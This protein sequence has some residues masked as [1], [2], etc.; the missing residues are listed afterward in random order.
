MKW[1]DTA[2]SLIEEKAKA[3]RKSANGYKGT[4]AYWEKIK[5]QWASGELPQERHPCEE[6]LRSFDPTRIPALI[7]K[8]TLE[9]RDAEQEADYWEAELLRIVPRVASGESPLENYA[10]WRLSLAEH[11]QKIATGKLRYWVNV[12]N[13]DHVPGPDERSPDGVLM[14]KVATADYSTR[15]GDAYRAQAAA[16][17]WE[18]F[19]QRELGR[20]MSVEEY[21]AAR[22]R[23]ADTSG[24]ETGRRKA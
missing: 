17:W 23:W 22:K 6:G 19:W 5:A 10:R 9:M 3:A 14:A 11:D 8:Y 12:S 1:M 24:R 21:E 4:L 13:G 15:V 18:E 2:E 7:E 20:I 16:I